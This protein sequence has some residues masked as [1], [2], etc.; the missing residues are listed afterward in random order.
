MGLRWKL[1]GEGES[2]HNFRELLAYTELDRIEAG[3]EKTSYHALLLCLC[4]RNLGLVQFA[5]VN[6]TL[7]SSVTQRACIC[8]HTRTRP[9]LSLQI[10]HFSPFAVCLDIG[11]N[12]NPNPVNWLSRSE[13][14][15]MAVRIFE[16]WLTERLSDAELWNFICL[17]IMVKYSVLFIHF[18]YIR[19]EYNKSDVRNWYFL[20]CFLS[21]TDAIL[22]LSNIMLAE[23]VGSTPLIQNLVTGQNFQI[24]PPTSHLYILLYYDSS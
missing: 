22:W 19:I 8:V 7:R 5:C 23:N 6:P 13:P 20:S 21:L 17:K 3:V 24:L 14:N 4:A 1:K 2:H 11:M 12:A 15:I 10:C 16:M 18:F 9:L